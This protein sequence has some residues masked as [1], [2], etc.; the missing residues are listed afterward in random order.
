MNFIIS[1]EVIYRLIT[2]II[3]L[4]TSNVRLY[5]IIHKYI[6]T[7]YRKLEINLKN[8]FLCNN[9]AI[10]EM[11]PVKVPH[12]L[13]HE[14]SYTVTDMYRQINIRNNWLIMQND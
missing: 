5:T 8:S 3:F 7:Y 14:L 2:L 11:L 12:T 10:S 1:L 6:Y 13:S 9:D 4:L